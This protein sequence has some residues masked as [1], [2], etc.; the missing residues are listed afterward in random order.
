MRKNLPLCPEIFVAFL[1]QCQSQASTAFLTLGAN[2]K[3]N[4]AVTAGQTPPS[5]RSQD[6]YFEPLITGMGA[7]SR[8][9][10]RPED[11]VSGKT[12]QGGE[13]HI[14]RKL[15]T[16]QKPWDIVTTRQ[17]KM[18][19]KT[20]PE[21]RSSMLRLLTGWALAINYSNRKTKACKSFGQPICLH[22]VLFFDLQKAVDEDLR[23]NHSFLKKERC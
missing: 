15:Q 4:K 1:A 20:R 11:F 12:A 23:L 14:P 18:V 9:N 16:G 13:D 10:C 21:S 7:I 17:L 5:L 2:K 22:V 6:M 8:Q 3:N 19:M